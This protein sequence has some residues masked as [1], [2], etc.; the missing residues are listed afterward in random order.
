MKGSIFSQVPYIHPTSSAWT[1]AGSPA[2]SPCPS[3]GEVPPGSTVPFPPNIAG[4]PAESA[5]T[6]TQKKTKATVRPVLG[7]PFGFT[8]T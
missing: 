6:T 4:L 8:R 3:T 1:L 2:Q 5:A 7:L